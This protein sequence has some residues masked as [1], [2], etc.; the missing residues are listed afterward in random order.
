MRTFLAPTIPR[1]WRRQWLRLQPQLRRWL[2]QL[3]RIQRL[4]DYYN[5]DDYDNYDYSDYD[6]CDD[7]NNNDYEDYDDY[8][9]YDS[10]YDVLNLTQLLMQNSHSLLLSSLWYVSFSYVIFEQLEV[11]EKWST[12]LKEG[13]AS[14]ELWGSR[15][16]LPVDVL[17]R[18]CICSGV[19]SVLDD[20]RCTNSKL[21]LVQ[22]CVCI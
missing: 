16:L 1:L 18:S 11:I 4:D 12:S 15:V 5:Y 17:L 3:W 21:S 9:D 7:Y 20:V 6:D 13:R 2:R 14:T 8:D 19:N 10:D 22:P